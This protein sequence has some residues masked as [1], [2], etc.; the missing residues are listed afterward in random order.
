M[1]NLQCQILKDIVWERFAVND[2]IMNFFRDALRIYLSLQSDL[3]DNNTKSDDHKK[4]GRENSEMARKSRIDDM[5]KHYVR[6]EEGAVLYSMCHKT[7]A[8]LAQ[9]ADAVR[10]YGKIKLVNTNKVDEYIELAC[11]CE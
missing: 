6:Y 2:Y 3:A 5:P 9:E 7:F 11:R 8:Q 1:L 4:I 10:E